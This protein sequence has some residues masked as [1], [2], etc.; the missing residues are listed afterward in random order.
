RSNG[1]NSA[2]VYG[3][4]AQMSSYGLWGKHE[5]TGYGVFGESLLHGVH[6]KTTGTGSTSCGVY[7]ETTAA[8]GVGG[9]A[10]TG[11]GVLGKSTSGVGVSGQSTS[12]VGV[13]GQSSSW[14]GVL[15]ES[16]SGTGVWGKNSS[17]IGVRGEAS[18][19]SA[20]SY[21]VF[22][23]NTHSGATGMLGSPSVGVYGERSGGNYAGYFVG[24]VDV[25]GSFS[26]SSGTKNFKIDHP[27]D[28]ENRYLLH[29]SVE[30][31]EV[32]DIYSG[33]VV[34]DAQGLAV[35]QLPDWFEALNTDF[36][37][38]L[39]VIGR[40][41]QAIVEQEIAGNRFT[42]RTNLGGVKVSWLVTTL[43][44]D[45]WMKAH[46]FQVEQDKPSSERGTLLAPELNGA[47]PGASVEHVH[48]VV[49]QP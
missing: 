22:G 13:S 36:R 49:S 12:G 25:V 8:T 31:S 10:T 44:N 46:P 2:G 42:I 34:T 26:V 24:N 20:G 6:G 3:V 40:F 32:L 9:G 35:V 14:T 28:P 17:G 11:S 23:R 5:G 7:G 18:G 48:G 38:Q 45:A 19:T 37:Y 30:S 33:N 29:A 21:G 1:S 39:T 27:L 47:P 43:R 4:T 16:S 41:A 15:G